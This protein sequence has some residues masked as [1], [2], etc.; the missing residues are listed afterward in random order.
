MMIKEDKLQSQQKCII[1]SYLGVCSF[2]I[3][4][5]S[6]SATGKGPSLIGDGTF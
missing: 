2:V 3:L 1:H 5:I 6:H 4:F